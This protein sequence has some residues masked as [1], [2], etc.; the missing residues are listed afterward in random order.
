MRG[1]GRFAR[2]R[3]LCAATLGVALLGGGNVQGQDFI[4]GDANADGLV[5]L[6][7]VLTI[8]NVVFNEEE[9]ECRKALDIDDTGALDI[10]DAINAIDYL[11]QNGLT[12][13]APFPACGEDP[14][15]DSLS[16][17][18]GTA[19]CRLG[20]PIDGLT[21]AEILSFNR[22]RVLMSKRFT[23]EEGLGPLYNSTS[24][25]SCH[26]K[27]VVGGSAPTY[28]NF[29]L[30]QIGEAGPD[31]YRLEEL[32][33]DVMPSYNGFTGRRPVIPTAPF[34]PDGDEVRVSQRNA[35]PFFGTGLF[36]FI[37]DA[38]ILANADPEDSDDDGISG[39]Y[40]T[41]GSGNLGRFGFKAQA[42]FIEA[43]IRGAA[44]NQMG[45]T[46]DPI[47]G[48]DG[49]VSLA[50]LQIGAG[51]DTPTTDDDGIP[52]P[53]ISTEDFGDIINFCR[54][55]RP[56]KPLPMSADALDGEVLFD[57]LG[58][59]SC[60][61]PSLDSSRGPVN[62]Y[63]DLLLHDMGPDLADGIHQGTPQFSTIE[64]FTT[65]SEFR[66]QPLWGLR[67]HAPFLHDGRADTIAEA[68]EAH[69][70]EAAESR[71]AYLDLTEEERNQLIEFLEA[72]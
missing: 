45:M 42:N 10:S 69:G 29:F 39:R 15:A 28:R 61:I 67:H 6:V 3:L 49:I 36:E 55:V 58:C 14:T 5:S 68:I 64:L 35:P 18:N 70:G 25:D 37:S 23:P 51:P 72:L 1:E 57:D 52:D 7:D 19:A 26:D 17:D 4:R 40:N 56:P 62:A 43:F 16:C 48:S 38:T 9:T 11:F 20:G 54:F 22:G 59:T 30:H 33:S 53:E 27:P 32:P 13:P 50:L 12:P 44:M 47:D 31:Q 71:D 60:H 65:V 63:T 41:D 8:L 21:A 24:C 46:T 2:W 66:T 34:G